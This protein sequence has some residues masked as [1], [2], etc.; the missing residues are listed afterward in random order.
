[1]PRTLSTFDRIGVVIVTI[2]GACIG[3]EMALASDIKLT[4]TLA[5]LFPG[6]VIGFVV[7][8]ILGITAGVLVCAA[9]NG[10]A[11]GLLLYGWNRL[12]SALAQRIPKWLTGA[13]VCL[14][15]V[16]KR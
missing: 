2:L 9:A 16:L 12:V 5:L 1:M 10:A 4:P 7:A 13:A 11:Y 15:H 8:Q 6:L 3:L 14:T